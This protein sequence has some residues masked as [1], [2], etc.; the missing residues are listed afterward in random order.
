MVAFYDSEKLWSEIGQF[1]RLGWFVRNG[2]WLWDDWHV[3]MLVGFVVDSVAQAIENVGPGS[4][5]GCCFVGSGLVF[6][7]FITIRDIHLINVSLL[8]DS[9]GVGESDIPATWTT[10]IWYFFFI[11]DIH[12]VKS[13]KEEK[14]RTNDKIWSYEI[15]AISIS[16]ININS[17]WNGNVDLRIKDFAL[18]RTTNYAFADCW[19]LIQP[20][21][22]ARWI[23]LCWSNSDHDKQSSN[24]Q[25]TTFKRQEGHANNNIYFLK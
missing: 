9:V 16:F 6:M 22:M 18:A 4:L 14:Q 10:L 17:K 5:Y 19:Q 15:L 2:D 13:T 1:V 3:P 23:G 25:L 24:S 8:L 11:I 20:E 12:W 21:S 7:V